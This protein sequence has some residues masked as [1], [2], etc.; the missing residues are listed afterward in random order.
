MLPVGIMMSIGFVLYAVIFL[1]QCHCHPVWHVHQAFFVLIINEANILLW[2]TVV[3]L[4]WS[5]TAT[6][7]CP[8]GVRQLTR[9]I[10]RT[11]ACC[12]RYIVMIVMIVVRP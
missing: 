8:S 2:Q 7:R 6:M 12:A 3:T 4:I 10:V 1:S 9:A 5:T 11:I